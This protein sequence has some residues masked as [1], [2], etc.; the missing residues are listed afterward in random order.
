MEK[1]SIVVPCYNEEDALKIFY[2]KITEISEKIDADFEYVFVDDG[3]SDNTLNKMKELSKKDE[4][5]KFVSF[6]RNFGKESAM[7]AGLKKAT[8]DYVALMDVDLQDPPELLEE[9]Y[10]TVS[11]GEYDCVATKRK[12]RK[13]EPIIRSLFSKMFYKL[14][15]KMTTT[16]I[17]D[18][19]RDYRLMSRKMVNSVL[20]LSEYNRFSK[21]IFSWV[22]YK[23]KW[24]SYNNIERSAG[25]TKWNFWKLFKYSI[26]GI[27]SFS[28]IP[29]VMSA[30]FGMLL[31]LVSFIMILI[32]I[33]KTLIYGDP[34]SGWPSTVCIILFVSGIQLFFLGI[35]GEYMAKAYMEIKNRPIYIVKETEEDIK[36]K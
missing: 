22:G 30:V 10:K 15:N 23:T 7:Y 32:I 14:I 8:G 24:L 19:A 29:L 20:E 28:T 27:T 34:V 1:I 6:S 2:D 21:G 26:E 17:I 11:S 4:R 12:T 33:G 16:E 5:V 25:K 9:M 35:I 18:G 36:N 31:C 3:S 13:G